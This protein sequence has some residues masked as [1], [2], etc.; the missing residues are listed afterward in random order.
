MGNIAQLASP[1]VFPKQMF[2]ALRYK[3]YL[4]LLHFE[5]RFNT[6]SLSPNSIILLLQWSLLSFSLPCS[7]SQLLT[8]SAMQAIAKEQLLATLWF[9]VD[10]R[11]ASRSFQLQSYPQRGKLKRSSIFAMLIVQSASTIT[12]TTYSI[13]GN[14]AYVSPLSKRM[15][16]ILH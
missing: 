14:D 2:R 6:K 11:T 7:I 9:Q 10:W 16:P 4:Q 12:E 13:S 15:Y 3:L 8:L 1:H 5:S